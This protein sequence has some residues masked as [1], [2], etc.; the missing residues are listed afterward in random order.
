[1]SAHGLLNLL[2]Q[3]R[4]CDKT[5]IEIEFIFIAYEHN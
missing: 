3:L 2:N 4:K 1:M 5:T